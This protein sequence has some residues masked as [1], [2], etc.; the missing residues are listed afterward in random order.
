[1]PSSYESPRE[2][3]FRGLDMHELYTEEAYFNVTTCLDDIYL[4]Q[5]SQSD[6]SSSKAG[7]Q[8]QIG[9]HVNAK[10]R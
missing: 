3:V 8:F 4:H 6:R 7:H 5:H 2:D 10:W 9:F 1:M